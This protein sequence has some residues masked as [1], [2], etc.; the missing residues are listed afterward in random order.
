MGTKLAKTLLV[1]GVFVLFLAPAAFA[2]APAPTATPAADPTWH[3]VP[4]GTGYALQT[5]PFADGWSRIKLATNQEPLPWTFFARLA[6]ET[7]VP[8]D[9]FAIWDSA[10]RLQIRG[11]IKA[12]LELKRDLASSKTIAPDPYVV[13]NVKKSPLGLG[14]FFTG[15]GKVTING[16]T[17]DLT[18]QGV[19]QIAFPADWTGVWAI[20]LDIPVGLVMINQG[21]RMTDVDNWPL[22][23]TP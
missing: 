7:N 15:N 9:S 20:D 23:A 1:L 14:W 16:T 21:E 10:T 6:P 2:A 17:I 19:F 4:G 13:A 3:Y 12:H 18:G 8:L 11:P 22:P 5:Q